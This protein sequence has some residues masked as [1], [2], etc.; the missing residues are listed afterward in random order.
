[1]YYPMLLDSEK[2]QILWRGFRK[3]SPDLPNSHALGH[4]CGIGG[5]TR[6]KMC[7]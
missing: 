1:M 7:F 6:T 4:V 3:I 2:R 5:Q